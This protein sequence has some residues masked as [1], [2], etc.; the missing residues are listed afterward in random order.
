[1][2]AQSFYGPRHGTVDKDPASSHRQASENAR[3]TQEAL[4]QKL[5]AHL[6][7]ISR[8]TASGDPSTVIRLEASAK[9]P[10]AVLLAH[11]APYGAPSSFIPGLVPAYAFAWDA[12]TKSLDVY[13]PDGLTA[14]QVYTL[15]FLV[16]EA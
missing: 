13:E 11:A 3:D 6:A 9:R 7:V 10:L 1:M 2:S 8:Y 5:S 12:T 14:G 4:D 15:T 16:V